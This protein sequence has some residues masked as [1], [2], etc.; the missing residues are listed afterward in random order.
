MALV[1][2]IPP[3]QEP[4]T[5]EEAKLHLRVDGTDEDGLI[6]GLI[7]TVRD[8]AELHTGRALMPQTWQLSLPRFPYDNGE[9][10]IPRPPFAQIDTVVYIDPDGVAVTMEAAD[11]AVYKG[12]ILSYVKPAYGVSWPSTRLVDDAVKITFQAGYESAGKVPAPIKAW[13][14]VMLTTLY[15]NRAAVAAGSAG[16]AEL[17]RRFCDGLLDPFVVPSFA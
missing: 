8:M 2:I 6:E 11:Y 17:P 3:A 13:M 12:A 14:K 7:E 10:Q 4:L 1:L 9:I 16:F 15:E 5:L